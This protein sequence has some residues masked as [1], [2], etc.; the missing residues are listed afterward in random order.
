[1]P[2]ECEVCELCEDEAGELSIN[3]ENCGKLVCWGCQSDIEGFCAECRPEPAR[4]P[5]SE[6]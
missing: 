5:A 6:H 1:M 4:Q 3:C 2:E